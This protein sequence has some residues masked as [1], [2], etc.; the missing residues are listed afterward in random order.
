MRT[1]VLLNLDDAAE[2]RRNRGSN[3]FNVTQ[4]KEILEFAQTRDIN[5]MDFGVYSVKERMEGRISKIEVIMHCK[6]S[7]LYRCG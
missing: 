1:D 5:N 7:L 6:V 4:E 2:Q 3:M